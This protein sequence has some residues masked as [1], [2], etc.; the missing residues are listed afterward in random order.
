M[1]K[2]SSGKTY[3]SKGERISS[4][5]TKNTDA[6]QRLL[7]QVRALNKGKNIV[8]TL[9]ENTKILNKKGEPIIKM[10]KTKVNG[11]EH[12]KRLQNLKPAK[13]DAE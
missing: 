12:L 7:N 2:K 13:A 6:G 11:K 8:F 5:S 10:V 3:T 1:A 9:P 4:I